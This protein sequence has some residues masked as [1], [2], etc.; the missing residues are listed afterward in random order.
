MDNRLSVASSHSEGV[1]CPVYVVVL[2][3]NQRDLTLECLASVL[4][5]NYPNYH[6]VVVD[7]GSNDGSAEAV[8]QQYPEVTVIENELNLGYAGGNNVGIRYALAHHADYVLLLNNDVVVAS[9]C[10]AEL[11]RAFEEQRNIGVA[12]PLI[13]EYHNPSRIWCAGASIDWCTGGTVRLRAGEEDCMENWQVQAVDSV[14]GSA[15]L[16][17]REVFEQVGLLDE[18]YFLYYEETEWCVGVRRAGYTVAVVPTAKVWHKVSAALGPRSPL[19]T[20]YMTRNSLRFLWRVLPLTR[21]AFPLTN[22]MA[23]SLRQAVADSARGR[24]DHRDA[25]LRGLWDFAH[26]RSGPWK[27]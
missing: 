2:N 20:Y 14:S 8:R 11:I 5:L 6:V 12:S 16:A 24:S 25:R 1:F 18:H 26:G 10:L 23:R 17:R 13:F 19:V 4:A 15:L 9:N 21:R 27:R 3:W 7:N 22:F